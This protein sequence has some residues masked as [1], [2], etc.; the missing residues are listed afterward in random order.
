MRK[1]QKSQNWK[2]NQKKKVQNWISPQKRSEAIKAVV[3]VSLLVLVVF[4]ILFLGNFIEG[5]NGGSGDSNRGSLVGMAAGDPAPDPSSGASDPSGSSASS[6][7]SSAGGSA[8]VV[9]KESHPGIVV[10]SGTSPD[11][12]ARSIELP[13]NHQIASY[14]DDYYQAGSFNDDGDFVFYGTE[15]NG[16]FY[17]TSNTF[18]YL[19]NSPSEG[20]RTGTFL[21]PSGDVLVYDRTNQV[22]EYDGKEYSDSGGDGFSALWENVED[23]NPGQVVFGEGEIISVSDYGRTIGVG[24]NAGGTFNGVVYHTPQSSVQ[25]QQISYETN[26]VDGKVTSEHGRR[27]QDNAVAMRWETNTFGDSSEPT[28]MVTGPNGEIWGSQTTGDV[29]GSN[30]ND[31]QVDY[32]T[33]DGKYTGKLNSNGLEARSEGR[34]INKE[35]LINVPGSDEPQPCDAST[36]YACKAARDQTNIQSAQAFFNRAGSGTFFSNLLFPE[37]R[38]QAITRW[39]RYFAGSVLDENY[40]ASFFCQAHYPDI[41]D[42][43]FAMIETPSGTF[44]AVAS[45]QAERT[46]VMPLLCELDTEVPCPDNGECVN[47][48]CVDGNG[49]VMEGSFVIITWGV[50]APAD[51]EFTPYVNENGIAITHNIVLTSGELESDCGKGATANGVFGRCARLYSYDGDNSFPFR[52][53]NGNSHGTTN[54]MWIRNNRAYDEV[55]IDWGAAPITINYW[56]AGLDGDNRPSKKDMQEMG[57]SGNVNSEGGI[58]IGPVCTNIELTQ[59]AQAQS[60]TWG[61]GGITLNYNDFGGDGVGV[62]TSS[63]GDYSSDYTI[64]DV[65][66]S[67]PDSTL[68]S[69]G[70]VINQV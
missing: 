19:E 15:Y 42:S 3:A 36:N 60:L 7:S 14:S 65:D 26:Y 51:E 22:M 52:L 46:E 40:W 33:F 41:Q 16:N 6:G 44:Q 66:Y 49:D 9:D 11:G 70:L 63:D 68:D 43:G 39:D 62:T 25:G 10:I 50:R 54:A 31:A 53:K 55:C 4:G 69:E 61:E 18:L 37:K 17:E 56:G 48:L 21:L 20:V 45:I 67:V 24:E 35:H 58:Q 1:G 12:M 2:K 32:V 38:A 27:I 5:S 47:D 57:A 29:Y 28:R 64:D 30:F 34:R 13:K 59:K 23:G 8:I